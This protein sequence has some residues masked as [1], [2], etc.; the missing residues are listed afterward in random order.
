MNRHLPYNRAERVGNVIY[1]VIVEAFKFK[2]SDPRLRGVEITRVRLTPDLGT[3][4]VSFHLSSKER[5]GEAL[6]GLTSAK[7]YM[8]R[9]IADAVEL[10]FMPEIEF[11]YDDGVD[12]T[13]RIDELLRSVR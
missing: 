1:K 12:A 10:K 7:G 4:R 9:L 2:L 8:K 5:Q 13:E 3:A 6:K 11:F